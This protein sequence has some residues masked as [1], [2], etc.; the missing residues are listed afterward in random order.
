MPRTATRARKPKFERISLR[1]D[2]HRG[3]RSP[4][5]VDRDRGI[6]FGIKI[7]G[8]ESANR[9]RYL[10]EAAK[11]ALPKYDGAKA[12]CDHPERPTQM[13]DAMDALGVWRNP[14]LESDGVY[15]DLHYFKTH[16]LAERVCEDA[17]RGLGVYGASHN[18]DGVG[19]NRD[20]VFVVG[21]ITEVR[22][23]DLVT[24]PATVSNLWEGRGAKIKR[25][26]KEVLTGKDLLEALTKGRQARLQKLAEAL[27]DT[28]EMEIGEGEGDHR[29][30]MYGAM[31]ACEDAG[32]ND[33]ASKIHKLLA[34]KEKETEEDTG[35]EGPVDEADD[36]SEPDGADAA[37]EGK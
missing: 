6:I 7:L 16:P 24:E 36:D 18:A 12:Y 26:V 15:A 35:V 5:K 4:L 27:P 30:Q 10:P 3:K 34:P 19:E 14:V 33:S 20:G 25:K 9:R 31:R 22:S 32:D 21:E 13:R 17:E 8:W 1:E 11:K 37:E 29:D 28:L 2:F 23:V